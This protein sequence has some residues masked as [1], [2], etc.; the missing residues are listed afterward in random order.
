MAT[1][2]INGVWHVSNTEQGGGGGG[3]STENAVLYTSQDLSSSQQAQA[4]ANIGAGTY[5][6][7]SGGIPAAD[8]A[9]GVIPASVSANPT[10]PQGT[11]PTA[12]STLQVGSN[13]FSVPDVASLTTSEI[14]TIIAN[15]A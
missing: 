6:K 7:P 8:M 2:K 11:T 1:E 9:D 15:V 12:L 14:D 10:V 4:R 5:S 13:Y 3:G